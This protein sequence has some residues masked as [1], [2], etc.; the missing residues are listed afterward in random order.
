MMAALLILLAGLVV[1]G[2]VIYLRW[3][4][5]RVWRASLVT[6][7]L[8]LPPTLTAAD[9]AAWLAHVVATT[10]ATGLAVRTPPALGLEVTADSGGITHTLLVPKSQTGS[11]LA[12]LRATL[13]AA[14]IEQTR[15]VAA[16]ATLA[17]EAR[18][19]SLTRPLAHDRA[20]L[21]SASLLAAL[22]PLGP[23]ERI[24]LQWLFTGVAVPAPVHSSGPHPSSSREAAH[25]ARL[26]QTDPLLQAVV[27]LGVQASAPAR[28]ASLFGPVWGA[29]RS[30]NTPGAALVRR[31]LPS[32]VVARRLSGLRL[33]LTAFPL[34]VSIKELAGLLALP[35]GVHLP[36]LARVTARQLPPP[37]HMPSTGTVLALSTYPGMANQPLA[38]QTRDRLQHCW[39]LGPTG[40]G[41]STLLASL[42]V[43][44]LQGGRA[45]VVLDPKGDLI[46]DVLDRVPDSR[47]DDV[48]VLDASCTDISI[49]L[50]VLDLGRG[51]H[52]RELAVDFLVH[53]M[54]SL[55]HSSWGPRTS[56]VLRMALLTLVS[57]RSADGSPFTLIELPEL[58]TNPAFRHLVTAQAT[59]PDG[60]R[61]F[62]LAY[63]QMSDGERAQVI[64]P[65]L[66]KLRSFTTRTALRL[67]LGQSRGIQLAD[68]FT[69]RR[70]LLVSL[71]KGRLGSDTAA[72]LGS[73]IVAGFWQ[74][75]LSRIDVP[76]PHRHPVMVYLDEFQD[77]VRLPLDLADLL[78]QARGLGVGVTLAHQYLGQLSDQ[79]KTAVLGTARTQVVFQLQPDDARFVSSRFTPMTADDLVGL[80]AYEVAIRPCVGGVT[81]GPVTGR[82]MPLVP[83]V[84]DGAA[85]ARASR[86]RF[87]VAR[88]LVEA[89]QR[90]R[91][92]GPPGPSFG[93]ENAGG[94]PS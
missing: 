11:V 75:T 77:I 9:V 40:V 30:L 26:K 71:A 18:L 48:I 35:L 91:L 1:F 43:Q 49:G 16:S 50:N 46:A 76:G 28:A 23:G 15:R 27:R 66:N 39:V 82:T 62:W 14:R 86:E 59:V 74:A 89:G 13:P 5:S 88:A 42:I 58:L 32:S 17:A 4:D 19:T 90:E 36:G 20:S 64:G 7:R 38:L 94:D 83:P 92:T 45:A 8:T 85:L 61:S 57:A 37:I 24:T 93:R 31:R 87:G 54:A 65:S 3:G 34:I 29:L 68:V 22:Q 69:R 21:A 53:L 60:V 81:Q 2:A 44:D 33:P 6:Y 52:A 84:R 12:G 10:H 25:S 63:E 72:L 67:M 55:W 78:A 80:A 51:E 79:V 41:K 56:D 47:Q 70:V 73:L